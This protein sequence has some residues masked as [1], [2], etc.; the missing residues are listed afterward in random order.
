MNSGLWCRATPDP[1]FWRSCQANR[2]SAGRRTKT[3]L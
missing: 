2:C 3:M 1:E